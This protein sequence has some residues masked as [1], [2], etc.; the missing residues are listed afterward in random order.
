MFPNNHF[1]DVS[2]LYDIFVDIII[3]KQF[4]LLTF[5][6]LGTMRERFFEAKR[7]RL[8]ILTPEICTRKHSFWCFEDDCMFIHSVFMLSMYHGY[9]SW[10]RIMAMYL[11]YASWLCIMAMYHWRCIM[12]MY[13][14]PESRPAWAFWAKYL[15]NCESKVACI[16]SNTWESYEP[17]AILEVNKILHW[18][19]KDV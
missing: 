14:E 4:I 5:W 6:R 3:I 8:H 18:L 16:F 15:I 7:F 17:E 1:W 10:L 12:A 13:F 19:M 2:E 9:V 11:G